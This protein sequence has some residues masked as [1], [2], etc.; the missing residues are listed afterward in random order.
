ML[1]NL[2]EKIKKNFEIFSLILLIITTILSTTYFNYSQKINIQN[3]NN[4]INNIYLKK[5]LN[6]IINN[7]EPK[8]KKINHKI[9]SGETFDK[10]LNSYSIDKK[11]IIAIK[12]NLKKK[13][14]LNKLNTKQSIQF[15]LDQTN[16]KIKEFTFQIS[17]TK[18]IYLVRNI[19]NDKFDQETISIKLN[20]KLFIKKI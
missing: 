16:N 1:K 19:K 8:Y 7:L 4:F 18:K 20:K 11:E 6:H 10:I 5:T 13:V 15:S 17:N 9:K 2:K 3:Y 12:N 14:N